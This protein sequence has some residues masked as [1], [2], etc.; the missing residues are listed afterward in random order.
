MPGCIGVDGD[1]CNAMGLRLRCLGCGCV[2]QAA[3][4]YFNGGIWDVQV[5]TGDGGRAGHVACVV[6]VRTGDI[7]CCVLE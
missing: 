2:V 5:A 7:G 3:V 6:C 4:G 1:A